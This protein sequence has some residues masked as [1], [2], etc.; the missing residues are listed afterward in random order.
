MKMK[1]PYGISS[2]FLTLISFTLFSCGSVR[3]F[4]SDLLA[5]RDKERN[6]FVET[7][8]G[9]V[10]EGNEAVLRSP[11]F[12]KTTIELDGNTR[13]PVKEIVAYQNRDAYYRRIK[14]QFAPRIKKGLIN[15]YQYTETYQT[16]S[17]YSN[18]SGRWSTRTRYYY[19]LQKGDSAN[20][21]LL[22]PE[23]IEEYVRDYG[24][25]MEFVDQYH[26][27]QRKVKMWSV[28]NTSA[29]LGG[30]A[31][32]LTGSTQTDS[33]LTAANY[34]GAG[35]FVGGFINGIVNKVRRAKNYKNLEL[36]IEEYNA[37]VKRKRK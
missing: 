4:R 16:Y 26:A 36:A 12:G 11:L 37:Q 25:A 17:T 32:M 3:K 2:L 8:D 1:L 20:I 23:L 18:G 34:T 31:L 9:T 10:I 15:M 28:I 27:T 35:L 21:A 24:P 33:K 5:S 19:Y 29:T 30:L 6:C 22:S 14:G 13:I 7:T